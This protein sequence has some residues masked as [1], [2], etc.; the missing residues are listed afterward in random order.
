MPGPEGLGDLNRRSGASQLNQDYQR[1]CHGG[2]RGRMQNDA[3][4]AVI[5]VRGG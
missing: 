1:R 5:R 2:G 4:L 3:E